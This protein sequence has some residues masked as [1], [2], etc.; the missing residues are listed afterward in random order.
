MIDIMYELPEYGGYEV[1]VTKAVIDD[2]ESPVYIKKKSKQI[3]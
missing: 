2:G 3:A 1:V